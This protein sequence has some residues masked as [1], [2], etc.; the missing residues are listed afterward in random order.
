MFMRKKEKTKTNNKNNAKKSHLILIGSLLIILGFSIVGGKY[1]YK[2]ISYKEET[3]IIEE[4][5]DT[6]VEEITIEDVIEE[7]PEEPVKE[8]KKENYNYIAVL[9]IPTIN[10]KKGLLDINDKN[11]NVDKNIEIL[12]NSDM[13]N[14]KNGLFALAG[15]SG[16]SKIA[17]FNKLHKVNKDDSIYI[18]YNNM[19]YTYKVTSITRQTKQGFIT[20][21]RKKDTTEL[22]LTTCDQADKTKQV[23]VMASLVET[24]NY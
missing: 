19:K 9:E 23:V 10:L 21:S 2:Y 1:I 13:P 12:Q 20:I 3:K 17:F 11:N 8:E 14:V 4:F 18:Y 16:N 22:L 7:T 6:E 15:H 24:S 5:L